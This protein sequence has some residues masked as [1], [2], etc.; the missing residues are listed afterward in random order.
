[1]QSAR[2]KLITQ[3][4][5]NTI[6]K[7]GVS[8]GFITTGRFV[9]GFNVL[10]PPLGEGIDDQTLFLAGQK[11]FR[12]SIEGENTRIKLM[13]FVGHRPL[14]VYTRLNIGFGNTTKVQLN[15]PFRFF[16]NINTAIA[17]GYREDNKD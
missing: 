11:A 3:A 8:H 6:A 2:T 5:V 13:H 1:M 12:F 7:T 4:I 15:A 16:N 9:V 10:N 14:Q 17:K